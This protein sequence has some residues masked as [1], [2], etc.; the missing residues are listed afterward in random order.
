ME[1]EVV[2]EAEVAEQEP[3]LVGQEMEELPVLKP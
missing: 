3:R 2:T 1:L